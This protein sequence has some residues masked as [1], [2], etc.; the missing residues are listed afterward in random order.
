[1]S[2]PNG[3]RQ[4]YFVAIDT[5][6][7]NGKWQTRNVE[8]ETKAQAEA[9]FAGQKQDRTLRCLTLCKDEGGFVDCIDSWQPK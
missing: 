6:D 3:G 4:M 7:A 5:N 1:M 9:F 8:F 2:P